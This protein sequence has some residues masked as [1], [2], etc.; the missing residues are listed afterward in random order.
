VAGVRQKRSPNGISSFKETGMTEPG[1]EKAKAQGCLCPN[2]YLI[3]RDCPLHQV[4][5]E[6]ACDDDPDGLLEDD[7]DA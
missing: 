5:Y 1:S 2:K 6:N 3:A 4:E 7:D